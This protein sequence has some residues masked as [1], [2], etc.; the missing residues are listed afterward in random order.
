MKYTYFTDPGHG[1]L[2]VPLEELKALGIADKI[3]S[4]SYTN[5]VYAYL[6][7]DCDM[8]IFL[9]AKFGKEFVYDD[10]K[11]QLTTSH[12][13]KTSRIRSYE[14]YNP[15]LFKSS[16]ITDDFSKYFQ[17]EIDYMKKNVESDISR[18]ENRIY[19]V[20]QQLLSD[21]P[22]F[23]PLGELQTLGIDIDV[24]IA[25]LAELI[26]FKQRYVE[27]RKFIYEKEEK[28]IE[29]TKNGPSEN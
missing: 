17:L 2:K 13:D 29:D 8:P 21:D 14:S 22:M 9:A 4:F 19:S 28:Q 6:E 24:S 20:K 26:K 7:E 5:G 23:N 15:D 16:K 10:Y 3:S 11:D 1:W 12:T 25:K 27:W 18:I